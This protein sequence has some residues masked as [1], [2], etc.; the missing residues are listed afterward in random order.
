MKRYTTILLVSLLLIA[1]SCITKKR[2]SE[3]FPC[4][5]STVTNTNTSV[6]E[7][8]RDTVFYTKADTGMV[9]AMLKCDSLGN[10]YVSRIIALEGALDSQVPTIDISDNILKVVMPVDSTAI[11]AKLKDRYKSTTKLEAITTIKE[12][13][14]LSGWQWFQ[15]WLGR[16]LS[17]LFLVCVVYLIIKLKF[18]RPLY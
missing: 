11:Y 15:I 10:V 3:R 8:L 18:K 16:V 6:I 17:L 7:T 13:N 5:E 4:T 14:I 2:C 9:I 12:I 1:S